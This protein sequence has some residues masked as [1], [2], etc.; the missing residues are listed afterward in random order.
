MAFQ[1]SLSAH[2]E[3]ELQTDRIIVDRI[4]LAKTY[5]V[6]KAFVYIADAP[7][8][9]DV[10]VTLTKDQVNQAQTVTISAGNNKGSATFSPAANFDSGEELGWVSTQ[11]GS[12]LPGSGLTIV[13]NISPE[14]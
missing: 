1:T 10:I 5:T 7:T 2:A 9:D 11:V 14:S 6:D 13:W 8:G 3:G 12:T 4:D